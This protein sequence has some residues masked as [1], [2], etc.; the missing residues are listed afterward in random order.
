[1]AAA[2]STLRLIS[3]LESPRIFRAKPMFL[4]TDMFG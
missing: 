4:S 3:L 1:M 2:S